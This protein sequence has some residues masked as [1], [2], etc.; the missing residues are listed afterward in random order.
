MQLDV[1]KVFAIATLCLP[2]ATPAIAAPTEPKKPGSA[3]VNCNALSSAG[4]GNPTYTSDTICRRGLTPPSLWWIREQLGA[5]PQLK[6]LI[7]NWAATPAPTTAQPGNLVVVVNSQAWSLLDYFSR[8][9]FLHSFGSAASTFGYQT[10]VQDNRGSNLASYICSASSQIK[11]SKGKESKD[12][13]SKNKE[14]CRIQF[15]TAASGF[16]G[17]RRSLF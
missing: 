17:G 13:E 10:E 1:V 9:E 14:Q 6:K 7:S 2:F 11:E 16:R 15:G 3:A 4:G 12:K 5:R 8:Y